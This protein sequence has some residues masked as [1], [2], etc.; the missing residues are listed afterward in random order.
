M[1]GV[2]VF[3]VLCCGGLPLL[4]AAGLS[5]LAFAWIGG[6]TAVVV[7]LAAGVAVVVG[8]ARRRAT[9]AA[10]GNEEVKRGAR[11][12]RFRAARK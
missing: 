8:R 3:A 4:A 12:L 6:V 9:C 2:T 5:G 1:A 7:A 10:P 11:L